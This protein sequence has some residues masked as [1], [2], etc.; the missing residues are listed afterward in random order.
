MCECASIRMCACQAEGSRSVPE[1]VCETGLQRE[2]WVPAVPKVVVDLD[3]GLPSGFPA[4]CF[5]KPPPL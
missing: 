1:S 5:P 4:Q 3:C 2:A